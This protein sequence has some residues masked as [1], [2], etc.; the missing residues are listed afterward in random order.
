MKVNIIKEDNTTI[1][2]I[3]PQTGLLII[4]L[5]VMTFIVIALLSLII[6]KKKYQEII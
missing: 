5:P 4:I 1:K 3:I 2:G 6:Y